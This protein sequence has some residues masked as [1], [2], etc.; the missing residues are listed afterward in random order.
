METRQNSSKQTR[1]D[2]NISEK[3]R[4]TKAESKDMD[5]IDMVRIACIA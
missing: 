4:M 5:R 3:D 2:M 1:I